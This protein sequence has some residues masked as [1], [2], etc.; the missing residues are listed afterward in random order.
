MDLSMA[1]DEVMELFLV[2]KV[3]VFGVIEVCDIAAI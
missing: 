3:G 2:A 1:V